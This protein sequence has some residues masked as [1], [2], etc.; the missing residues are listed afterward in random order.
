MMGCP[1]GLGLFKG[2]LAWRMDLRD[3]RLQAEN[4]GEI[5]AVAGNRQ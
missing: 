4:P 5:P 2:D 3:V 1:E